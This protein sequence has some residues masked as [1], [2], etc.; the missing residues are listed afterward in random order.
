MLDII[1]SAQHEVL[2]EMYWF[3]SDRTGRAFAE[4]LIER[5]QAGVCV[6]VIYD[7]V[8]SLSAN[9]S[10]FEEMR[11]AGCEVEEYNPIAPWR[12]RFSFARNNHR[13]HRKLVV[14][15]GRIAVTGGINIGDPWAPKHQGGGGFRD[16]AVEIIGGAAREL[17]ALFY[18]TFRGAP[19]LLPP[20]ERAAGHCEVVV[21]ASDLFAERR[22]IYSGYLKAIA[23]ATQDILIT[24]SY[25]IPTNRVRRALIRAV[26]RGVRVRVLVPRNN[27]V[28]MAQYASRACYEKL[29]KGG[30]E[31]YEWLGGILHGKTAAVDDLWCTAGSF[32][33]DALS[34]HNNL[35]LNVA[36]LNQE[37]T[38]ALRLKVEQDLLLAERVELEIFQQRSLVTRLIEAFFH[39]F[40]WLL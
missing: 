36:I 17:R 27:D 13:D 39:S 29:L 37:V 35:E 2:V 24:N 21:L 9:D 1:R 4:A 19:I 16:D 3:G 33:F 5:A 30:V 23:R 22:D 6:R 20:Y 7:S 15:D 10:M 12:A 11:K 32:N 34:L 31:I 14:A 26:Q 28:K 8:G 40:R 18:R 25:F 38:A